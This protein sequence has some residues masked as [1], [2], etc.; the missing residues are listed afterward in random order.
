MDLD[1]IKSVINS[2]LIN[3]T[4]K[5]KLI[6]KILSKD[7]KIIP[8]L[9]EILNSEREIEKEIID[10]LNLE[11]SRTSVYV[12]N[13]KETKTEEQQGFNRKFVLGEVEKF[14]IKYKNRISHCFN[15]FN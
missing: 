3:D 10:D 1:Q 7:K 5:E 2:N 15:M 4:N 12:H 6:I 9:L 13:V 11:L 8:I 14:Y